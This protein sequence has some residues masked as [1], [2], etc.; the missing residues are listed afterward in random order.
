M[1][2]TW[3]KPWYK[4]LWLSIVLAIVAVGACLG[5][6]VSQ[7]R[8]KE[9]YAHALRNVYEDVFYDFWEGLT[10]LEKDLDKLVTAGDSAYRLVLLNDI[11][12]YSGIAEDCIGK[13][14]EMTGPM[15]STHAFVNRLGDY[16]YQLARTVAAGKEVTEEQQSQ[17]QGLYEHCRMLQSEMQGIY[18]T[19]QQ[20]DIDWIAMYASE[21]PADALTGVQDGFDRMEVA[22]MSQAE[23]QYEG[24]FSAQ[25]MAREP[26]GVTGETVDCETAKQTLLRVL[27][28][29]TSTECFEETQG[30]IACYHFN[31]T[32]PEGMQGTAAVT[33]TGGKV[34][35]FVGSEAA[36]GDVQFDA[37]ACAQIAEQFAQERLD[38]QVEAVS[39]SAEGT[40]GIVALA[41]VQDGVLLYPD[42]FTLN[43]CAVS[44]NV[45]AMEMRNYARYSQTRTW[46]STQMTQEQIEQKAAGAV[47]LVRMRRVLVPLSTGNEVLCYEA[48]GTRGGHTFLIFYNAETGTEEYI[49]RLEEDGMTLF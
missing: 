9:Q 45:T 43:V 4:Y 24:P 49:Y 10:N 39:V 5:Y 13:L 32:T 14:P 34:L 44:G 37:N 20:G 40:C 48:M 11:W 18:D 41:P 16:A 3:K 33:K 6:G 46:P 31:Y 7:Q 23:L 38:M 27:G 21:E 25:I 22:S 30:D 8:E 26:R 28:D 35:S 1:E 17:W 19:L 15:E 36:Q 29:G 42:L 12:R 2:G 47:R